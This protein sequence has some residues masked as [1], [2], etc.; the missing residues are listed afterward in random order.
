MFQAFFFF[1]NYITVTVSPCN[2]DQCFVH[3]NPT[4]CN[5]SLENIVVALRH[6]ID[7]T[8]SVVSFTSAI[9]NIVANDLQK[10][11]KK[12]KKK[13]CLES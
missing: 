9:A 6:F 4:M 3:T 8:C 11:K 2:T 12:K 10:K 5:S 13:K 7:V 1:F